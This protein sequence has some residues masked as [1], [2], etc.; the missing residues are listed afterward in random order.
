[1]TAKDVKVKKS[2]TGEK[3]QGKGQIRLKAERA[4]LLQEV[5]NKKST[6]GN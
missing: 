3:S 2:E 6:P 4:D 5:R 1:M